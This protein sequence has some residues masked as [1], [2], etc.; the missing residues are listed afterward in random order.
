MSWLIKT[1]LLPRLNENT[2]RPL[3]FRSTHPLIES[4][5]DIAGSVLDQLLALAGGRILD[6][7]REDHLRDRSPVSLVATTH[8]HTG[9]GHGLNGTFRRY[10]L[11]IVKLNLGGEIPGKEDVEKWYAGPPQR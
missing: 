1:S 6:W 9:L 10:L 3:S 11:A 2:L 7:K 5:G 8:S 4:A